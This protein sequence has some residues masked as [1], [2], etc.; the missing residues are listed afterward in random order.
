MNRG[1]L[2][3]WIVSPEKVSQDAFPGL[4][5]LVSMYPYFQ[6]GWALMAKAL[7][8]GNDARF[9]E[10]IKTAALHSGNRSVLFDL[11]H[12]KRRQKEIQTS[13][14]P[15][16]P[17][18][19]EDINESFPFQEF[20]FANER[21][22]KQLIEQ[23]QD[24]PEIEN[25]SQH[26]P[27]KEKRSTYSFFEW[28]EILQGKQFANQSEAQ[29]DQSIAGSIESRLSPSEIIETFIRTEPK[30]SKPDKKAFFSPISMAKK[31]IED[32]NEI[33]SE[34]LARVYAD[35]GNVQKAIQVYEKL[36]LLYPEK[37]T[38]FAAL[39]EKLIQKL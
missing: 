17:I 7:K 10:E 2:H 5:D 14:E 21:T 31:S 27:G 8:T 37:N 38:Y 26:S 6:A 4:K 13:L 20:E 30:I 36:S 32:H 12:E 25:E 3:E 1:L 18:N 29:N 15:K 39:V 33:V 23:I 28:L 24:Y 22:E 16:I 34:T 19:K 35:Q 11:L 9:Y